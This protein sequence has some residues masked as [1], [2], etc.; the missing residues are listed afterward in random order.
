MQG[1]HNE[2]RISLRN[3]SFGLPHIL[4]K[5]LLD[6]D[7]GLILLA[8]ALQGEALHAKRFSMVGKFFEDVIGGLD[9]LLVLLGLIMF[10]DRL[11]EILFLLGE[12]LALA[13][14]GIV[15][16]GA[17]RRIRL[18]GA[19]SRGGKTSCHVRFVSSDSRRELASFEINQLLG[20]ETKST[21]EVALW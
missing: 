10:D 13:G 12:R 9:S 21:R 14:L 3:H 19:G 15:L 2:A 5:S 7:D 17:H 18:A 20:D 8:H 1:A 11:E 4:H 6:E 16:G